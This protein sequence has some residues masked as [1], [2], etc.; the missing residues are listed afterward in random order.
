MPIDYSMIPE[1]CRDGMRR[2]IEQGVIPGDF[3]QAV[4]CNDLVLAASR[5]DYINQQCLLDYARFLYNA[6]AGAWGN[7]ERMQRWSEA[8]GLQGLTEP[9]EDR[10]NDR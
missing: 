2:Y 10:T 3:L 8:G 6:P 9:K 5:A 1:H 7:L 4:I